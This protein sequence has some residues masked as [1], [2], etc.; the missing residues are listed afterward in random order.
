MKRSIIILAGG[1]CVLQA[2]SPVKPTINQRSSNR[3]V[4]VVHVAPR[5]STA[6]RMPEPVSSVVVGDPTKFLVEHSEKEPTLV[7]VKPVAEEAAESNLLVTTTSGD[8]VSFLLRSDGTNTGVV[9]FLVVYSPVTTFII[10]GTKQLTFEGTSQSIA[11]DPINELLERQKR[12][13]TPVLY[14]ERAP[15][16]DQ[17][18]DRVKAGVSE[19]LDKGREVWVLFS[20]INLQASAVELLP[21][22]IQLAGRTKSGMLRRSHWGTS[23]QLPAVAYRLS[24]QR[25]APGE[26]ADGVAVF[27]RP[28]FKQSNESLFLQIAESGAVDKPALAPIGFGVSVLK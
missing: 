9:D 22:Q 14:G 16:P 12:A 24:P 27:N 6:I 17:N 2:Q 13:P 25:L 21:P 1:L 28:S 8:Q 5:Y 15:S 3:R 11:P 10:P 7:L 23:E 26:R 4:N 19:V 20:V 18:R